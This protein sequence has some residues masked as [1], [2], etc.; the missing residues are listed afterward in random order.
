MYYLLYGVLVGVLFGCIDMFFIAHRK[1]INTKGNLLW[2]FINKVLL[3]FLMGLA[4]F[5]ISS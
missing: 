1:S 2:A 5:L 3:G 4:K